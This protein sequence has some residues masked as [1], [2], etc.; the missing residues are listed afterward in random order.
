MA[1]HS[2][3][4]THGSTLMGLTVHPVS[5]PAPPLTLS[6]HLWPSTLPSFPSGLLLCPSFLPLLPLL[7]FPSPG[8]RTLPS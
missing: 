1:V 5:A 3:Q 4:Y 8:V 7:P 2:W 6:C